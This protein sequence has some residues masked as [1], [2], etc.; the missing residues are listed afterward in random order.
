MKVNEDLTV[1]L[2]QLEEFQK[3]IGF[4]FKN[5]SILTEA[6]THGSFY[7]GNKRKM[8]AFIQK[9]HLENADY[10]KLENLGDL[11]LDLIIGDFFYHHKEIEEYARS[12]DL[13]IEAALTT[14]KIVLVE[15][16]GLVP[17]AQKLELEKY[18][19]YGY[20]D[21]VEDIF[22]DVIEALIGAIYLDQ[23]LPRARE[24]VYKYF[25]IESA[26]EKVPHSNPVGKVQDI[27]GEDNINYPIIEETGPGHCKMFTVGLEIHDSIV[28]TGKATQVR[29]AKAEAARKH[30]QS[31]KGKV[32]PVNR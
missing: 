9:N 6:L 25:D 16:E 1:S 17:V 29:K 8:K 30:L 28:S 18:I 12:N 20:L 21:S 5:K 23:G 31:L 14:V 2:D 27:Y 7:S 15:N 4:E 22:D 24:F 32:K 19:I 13:S 3:I 10:N 26:L 11:V